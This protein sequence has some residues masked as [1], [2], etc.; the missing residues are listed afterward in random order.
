MLVTERKVA[1]F[2]V[3]EYW[4]CDNPF[5][6]SDCDSV[7]FM[8]CKDEVDI[9]GFKRTGFTTL[10]LDLTKSLD[11]IWHGFSKKSCQYEIKRAERD[12]VSVKLSTGHEVFHEL[13]KVFRKRKG[14]SGNISID[15]MQKYCTLFLAGIKGEIVAGQLYLEDKD[16]IRW[17]TG[18]S[19][20]LESDNVLIGCANRALIWEAIKYAKDKGIKEFDFG[21]YHT[22][23]NPEL[24]AINF[25]KES[26][27]GELVT[28]YTYQKNY[29]KLFSL[30]QKLK[31]IIVR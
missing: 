29:S 28:R 31:K 30:A 26:F 23:D 7:T 2:R 6:V 21:G 17:L 14:L 25:F 12:G 18:A 22:G 5:D 15:Y 24:K 27:G 16:N 4:S 20:R 3:K 11:E 1:I 9:K 10:I 13:N 19:K 8:A